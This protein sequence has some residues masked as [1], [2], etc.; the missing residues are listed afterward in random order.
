MKQIFNLVKNKIQLPPQ[1]LKYIH[2]EFLYSYR[3]ESAS[4]S[5]Y[6]YGI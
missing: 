6:K 3:N 2:V 5:D 4:G 1:V